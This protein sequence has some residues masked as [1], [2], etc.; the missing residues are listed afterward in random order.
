MENNM[1][2]AFP[3]VS[4]TLCSSEKCIMHIYFFTN[5]FAYKFT[6]TEPNHNY[7]LFFTNPFSNLDIQKRACFWYGFRIET[8]VVGQTGKSQYLAK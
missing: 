8:R 3:I 1:Q 7:E 2:L 5:P 4:L 6:T